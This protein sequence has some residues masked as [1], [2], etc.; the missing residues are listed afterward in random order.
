LGSKTDN[1]K[2]SPIEDI[3][4][5]KM[6]TIEDRLKII[7]G[8]LSGRKFAAELGV[9]STTVN[10]YLNGRTP[11]AEFIVLVCEHYKVDS[12]W[13]LTG[14]GEMRGESKHLALEPPEK[15]GTQQEPPGWHHKSRP[16]SDAPSMDQVTSLLRM[17][18]DQYEYLRPESKDKA[19]DIAMIFRHFV[20]NFNSHDD[21]VEIDEYIEEWF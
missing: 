7:M 12:W 18:I 14:T 21:E 19:R 17:I 6:S 11:P 4:K 8:D 16:G 13:L 3:C 20:D 15:Y 1:A 9:S 2:I 10:Q 5:V